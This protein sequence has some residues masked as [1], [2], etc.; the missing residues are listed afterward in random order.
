MLRIARLADHPEFLPAL[1]AGY[2]AEWPAWYARPGEARADLAGRLNWDRLPLGL[3]AVTHGT[4]IGTLAI[5]ERDNYGDPAFRPTVIGLWVAPAHRRQ[6][7]ATALLRTA[8]GEARALGYAR[9][10]A[11]TASAAALFTRKNWK[12]LGEADWRGERLRLFAFSL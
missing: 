9:L 10:H 12:S 5:S 6:G 11:A 4:P 1:S 7:V 3:V 2:E 8:C